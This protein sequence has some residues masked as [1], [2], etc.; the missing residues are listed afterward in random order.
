MFESLRSSLITLL[1]K[2][3]GYKPGTGL[4]KEEQ[5]IVQPISVDTNLGMRG[6]GLQVPNLG[7]ST[8]QWDFSLE[9]PVVEERINWLYNPNKPRYTTLRE[10]WMVEGSDNL[11]VVSNSTF[12]DPNVVVEV[13]K[14][15]VCYM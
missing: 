4:G 6:L 1:Q 11:D 5:G 7:Y 10:E 13:F 12:C 15:K 2:N 9:N 8:E 3:M 14:A